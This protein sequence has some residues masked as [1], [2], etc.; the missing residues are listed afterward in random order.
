MGRKSQLGIRA[1]DPYVFV[2]SAI[3]WSIAFSLCRVFFVDATKLVFAV[4]YIASMVTMF[5]WAEAQWGRIAGLTA[6]IVYGFAPYRF[7]DL[8]VRG[9]IGEHTAFV[10]LPIILWGLLK[11]ARCR[12][13]RW[14]MVV[15][16]SIA[17]LLLSHNAMSLMFLPVVFL[18]GAYLNFLRLR[19]GVSLLS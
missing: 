15:A 14:G 18:Y 4:A 13:R 17:G 1:P 11:L 5:V 9:A 19:S 16:A 6:A 10:F 8:Y 3:L 7:V 2:S 12:N